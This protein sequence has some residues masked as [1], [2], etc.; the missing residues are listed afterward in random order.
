MRGG[1]GGGGGGGGDGGDTGASPLL[2]SAI[3]DL[4]K[5]HNSPTD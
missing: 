2:K 4:R 1:G 3:F 5:T